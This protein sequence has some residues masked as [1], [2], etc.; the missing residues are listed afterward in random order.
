MEDTFRAEFDS[1]RQRILEIFA[2]VQAYQWVSIE[3]ATD[4]GAVE[5]IRIK[6]SHS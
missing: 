3:I 6:T 4:L 5:I 1:G 2:Q